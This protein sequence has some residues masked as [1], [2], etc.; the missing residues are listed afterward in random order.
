MTAHFEDGTA[1]TGDLLIGAEGSNSKVREF[2][3]GADK[4]A[5]QPIALLGNGALES[6]PADISRKI[7]KINDLCLVGYHPE[8]PCIFMAR[9]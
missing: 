5:L 7:H 9:T 8:G 3:L 6:L 1:V 2:L 4:A